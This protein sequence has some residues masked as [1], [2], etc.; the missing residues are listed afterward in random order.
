WHDWDAGLSIYASDDSTAGSPRPIPAD[1]RA[2]IEL[3]LTRSPGFVDD[4]SPKRSFDLCLAGHTHGGQIVAGIWA[5][6]TPPG[7]GRFVAGWYTT[8][9]GPLYVSRGTG[10][11]LV[12]ARF[13]CRLELPLFE[14]VRA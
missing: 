2:P 4:F 11:S 14:L 1:P 13:C 12:P 7:S 6:V 10:T 9:M 8:P 3:L 5:P